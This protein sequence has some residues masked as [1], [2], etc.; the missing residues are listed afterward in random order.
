MGRP[1]QITLNLNINTLSFT[2]G[3][4]GYDAAFYLDQLD[5]DS[6]RDAIANA[7]VAL[8]SP[9]GAARRGMGE[10]AVN[11]RID[12]CTE[13]AESKHQRA[14]ILCSASMPTV[15]IESEEPFSVPSDV[16]DTNIK[17]FSFE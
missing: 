9:L 5:K 17:E 14:R 3:S 7:I 15:T 2:D 10:I 12:L 11:Q 1:N 4:A 13:I 16:E 6:L 8:Y